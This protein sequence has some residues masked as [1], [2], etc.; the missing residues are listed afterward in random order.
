MKWS[1]IIVIVFS[2]ITIFELYKEYKKHNIS[3][4]KYLI[5]SVME[6]VAVIIS[7]WLFFVI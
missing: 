6:A 7:F 3:K 4:K 1:L 5:I 2:L